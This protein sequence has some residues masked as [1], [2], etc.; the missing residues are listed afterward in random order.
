[1]TF[2]RIKATETSFNKRRLISGVGRNDV[3]YV[4]QPKVNGKQ[5]QCPYFKMWRQMLYRCYDKHYGTGMTICDEWL[6]LAAFVSWAAKQDRAGKVLTT[7]RGMTDYNPESCL[8]LDS[9]SSRMLHGAE[10]TKGCTFQ[11]R[12]KVWHAKIQMHGKTHCLGYGKTEVQAHEKYR[13]ARRNYI[14]KNAELQTN[15]RVKHEL[16]NYAEAVM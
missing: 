15:A 4:T 10:D 2:P 16:T 7:Y 9:Y 6:S 13:V 14:L 5:I 1:M 12:K 3:W 8:F 11:P